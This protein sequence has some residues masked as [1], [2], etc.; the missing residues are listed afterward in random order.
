VARP[1]CQ[2]SVG[3]LKTKGAKAAYVAQDVEGTPRLAYPPKTKFMKSGLLD[4]Y[5]DN[6]AV[7]GLPA[8]PTYETIPEHKAMQPDELHLTTYKIAV[9]THSRT[10]HCKWLAE[11]KHDNPG[12]MNTKT[13]AERGI[14]DGDA[15]RVYNK[16]GEIKTTVHVTE[17]I[18]PGVIAIS[19]SLGRKYSG[20]YGSGNPSPLPGVLA[21]ADD[22][23][24]KNKWW[25]K[26]GQHPNVII[27]NWSDPISGTQRWMDTVVRVAKA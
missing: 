3:Y 1:Q 9:H 6:Y 16:L 13:A 26:H 22:P 14:K 25:K 11:I 17:G 19:H 24:F 15:I 20:R 2:E 5:S 18:I 4:F 7:K 10:A 27:P 12:W 8:F 23:D 21:M